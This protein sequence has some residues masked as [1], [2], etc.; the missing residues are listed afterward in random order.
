MSDKLV[1]E[2]A[3]EFYRILSLY[4]EPLGIYYADRKPAD[5]ITPQ[6]AHLPT[7]EEEQRGTADFSGAMSGNSCIFQSILR[8][9]KTGTAACF[10]REHYGCLGGA[11]ALGFNKPQLDVVTHYVSTGF[12]GILEGERYSGSPELARL[13]FDYVDPRPPPMEYTIFKQLSRFGAGEVPELVVFFE[14]P[15]VISGLHQLAGFLLNDIDV[16]RSPLG[17]GCFNM[18]TWPIKYLRQG[19]MKAVLGGWDPS[20]RRY[21]RTDEITFTV[22]YEMFGMMVTRWKESFL[23]LEGNSTWEMVRKRVQL[24]HKK[25]GENVPDWSPD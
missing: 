16:V 22:P 1:L 12:E 21:F 17:A 4:E 24:S 13:F 23:G 3:R 15:E 5:C 10:D 19:E 14:R 20:C 2:G 25:W 6:K 7:Y 11:F 8:A 18:V 9:R